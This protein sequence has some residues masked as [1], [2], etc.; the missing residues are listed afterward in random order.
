VIDITYSQVYL[1]PEHYEELKGEEE[2]VKK[3]YHIVAMMEL[4]KPIGITRDEGAKHL[5]LSKRQTYRLIARFRAEGVKGLRHRSRC[6]INIP[7][8]TPKWLENIVVK[9][10]KATGLSNQNTA[11]VANKC[12]DRLGSKKTVYSSL[13]SRIAVRYGVEP[14]PESPKKPPKFFDWKRANSL[15]QTDLTEINS[16]PILTMEDDHTRKG[17]ASVLPN[18]RAVTVT[19][20]MDRIGPERYNNLLTDNGKQFNLYNWHMRR[21]CK[22]HVKYKHIHAAVRHPQTMG[23]LSRY[24]RSMKEFLRY[25]LGVS[26]NRQRLAK[27]IK[28]FNLFY[29]NGRRHSSTGK[30]P[31][32]H[33]SGQRNEKWFDKLMKFFK[34]QEVITLC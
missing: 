25:H 34:L 13:V 17:W 8:I 3:R 1:K 4:P 2:Y 19:R 11:E 18:E 15:I 29:N 32:E 9:I 5:H 10:K 31:E 22:N 6:P 24:Q 20:E 23:K 21:Y 28:I 7:N 27:L 26:R 33:Y 16:V 30:Y 12:L 14:K